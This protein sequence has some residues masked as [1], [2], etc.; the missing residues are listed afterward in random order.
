MAVKIRDE[1]TPEGRRFMEQ[2]RQ[3]SG[4]ETRIGFQA[5]EAMHGET[6]MCKIAMFNE[7]GTE[8]IPSRPF[9]RNS[10][11]NHMDEIEAHLKAWCEKILQGE[12]EAHELMSN[13]GML[14]QGII[15][16]EISEGSFVPNAPSTVSKKGSDRPLI[17]S[18]LMRDSVNYQIVKRGTSDD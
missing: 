16:K 6:D 17:D 5:G 2:M 13:M 1:I 15:R 7:L 14:M 8:S 3:I 12:M 9:L 10:V 11:D 4:M 18:G